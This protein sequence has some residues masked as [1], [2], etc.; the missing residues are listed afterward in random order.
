[1]SNKLTFDFSEEKNQM[2]KERWGF[3]FEYVIVHLSKN[4]LLDD[5][6]HKNR[7]KYARQRVFVVLIDNYIFLVPYVRDTVRNVIFLKTFFK[8]REAMKRY[9]VKKS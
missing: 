3:G 4:A 7:D 5:L 6:R 2:Q 8:S 1:M 9:K